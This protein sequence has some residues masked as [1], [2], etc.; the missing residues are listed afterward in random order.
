MVLLMYLELNAFVSLWPGAR[1]REFLIGRGI[2]QG[3]PL[4]PLLFGL[5]M[6][7]VLLEVDG[8]WQR[9]GYGSPVGESIR[10]HRLTHIAFVDDVTLVASSWIT[11]K[12]MIL[13]LRACLAKYGLQLHPSKCKV[14]CNLEGNVT[15]GVVELESQ[16]SVSVLP[17]EEGLKILGTMLFFG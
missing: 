2:R 7:K 5:F 13:E 10:R 12:R 3:D 6:K 16:F 14:Q 9:R 4:S 1:S 8:K 11:F 17:T 15:R